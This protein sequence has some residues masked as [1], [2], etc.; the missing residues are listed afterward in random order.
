M[1]EPRLFIAESWE[2]SA[3][4]S[5]DLTFENG[6]LLG[7]SVNTSNKQFDLEALE[8][9]GVGGEEVVAAA[10]GDRVKARALKNAAIQKARKVDKAAF[11]DDFRSGV[12]DSKAFAHRQQVQGRA[13]VDLDEH[14]RKHQTGECN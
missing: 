2:Q 12:I 3:A 1:K 5:R 14:A 11:L 8:V 10:L 6:P 9:W 7:S 13:D 4:S